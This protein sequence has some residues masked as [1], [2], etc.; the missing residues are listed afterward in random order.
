MSDPIIRMIPLSEIVDPE[1]NSRLYSESASEK[2]EIEDLADSM[3]SRGQLQPIGVEETQPSGYM[4]VWGSRRVRAA[5]V[6]GWTEIRAEVMPATDTATRV[7]KNILENVKRKDLTQFEQ[8]RA[9]VKLREC[10]MTGAQV[11]DELGFS[12]QKVSNLAVS[13]AKMP[14]AILDAWRQEDPCATVDFLRELANLEGSA[15]ASDPEGKEQGRVG[16]IIAAWEARKRLRERADNI[17]NPEERDEKKAPKKDKEDGP[18]K[19]PSQRYYDLVRAIQKAAPV[20]SKLA[21]EALK[22]AVGETDVIKGI[23]EP[24]AEEKPA[25]KGKK[26]A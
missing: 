10:G 15:P 22:Y 11:G 6:N 21:I 5:K 16:A 14:P 19:V 26:A 17:L 20:G 12:K 8:A 13:Y 24:V 23:I 9:C 1:W 4:L 18:Y 7:V 25:K 3:K 2:R